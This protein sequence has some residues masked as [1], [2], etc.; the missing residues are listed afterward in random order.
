MGERDIK[1]YSAHHGA[2]FVRDVA[3]WKKR[4]VSLILE[5]LSQTVTAS[6]YG[7]KSV[8]ENA[9]QLILFPSSPVPYAHIRCPNKLGRNHGFGDVVFRGVPPQTR[10]PPLLQ[11]YSC[12]NTLT[13]GFYT[14]QNM[15]KNIT[16][17]ARNGFCSR[18]RRFATN[19]WEWRSPAWQS[20]ANRLLNGEQIVILD[21][22]RI[23]VFLTCFFML[24]THG[25]K[26]ISIAHFAVA[27]K[28]SLF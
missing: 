23:T 12:V 20:L 7:I 3:S 17:C 27:V 18:G 13:F 26:L 22:P 25:W 21:N 11:L 15:M 1:W 5:I 8:W 16:W 14:Y 10:I 9:C 28:D 6:E 2:Q 24:F 4:V 19:F